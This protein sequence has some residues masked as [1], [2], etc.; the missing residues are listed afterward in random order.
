M[1]IPTIPDDHMFSKFLMNMAR[2]FR[3]WQKG[4]GRLPRPQSELVVPGAAL[5]KLKVCR[6]LFQTTL[7]G[8]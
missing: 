7:Q 3:I 1:F 2:G 8:L 6:V 5:P 4:L